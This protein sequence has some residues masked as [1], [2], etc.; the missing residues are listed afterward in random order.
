MMDQFMDV[1][2]GFKEIEGRLEGSWDLYIKALKQYKERVGDCDVPTG[3][4]EIVDGVGGKIR[5]VV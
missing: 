3:H 2:S 4:V 1:V 5:T